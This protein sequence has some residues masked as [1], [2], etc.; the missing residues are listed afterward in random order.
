MARPGLEP[1]ICGSN[2]FQSVPAVPLRSRARAR[3]THRTDLSVPRWY[4]SRLSAQVVGAKTTPGATVLDLQLAAA[5]GECR[6]AG[7]AQDAPQ[8]DPVQ[9]AM[10]RLRPGERVRRAAIK[11]LI[12]LGV[13]HGV[14][15]GGLGEQIARYYSV[16]LA[17][18]L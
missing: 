2:R 9:R 17:P 10:E 7:L 12:T 4:H 15:V 18:P 14:L 8:P 3:S 6:Y 1:G 13:V 11:D 16:D 5:Y